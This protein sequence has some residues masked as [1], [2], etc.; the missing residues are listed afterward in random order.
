MGAAGP[1]DLGP[2]KHGEFV[3]RSLT[4]VPKR[5]VGPL[6]KMLVVAG[7]TD[8]TPFVVSLLES[9]IDPR[10]RR[11]AIRALGDFGD[12][13]SA[14]ALLRVVETGSKTERRFA[15]T[16]LARTKDPENLNALADPS[17]TLAPGARI[18]LLE[19]AEKFDSVG[20]KLVGFAIEGLGES[21]SA[22]RLASLKLLGKARK[23]AAVQPLVT[24][25]RTSK[26]DGE[27]SAVLNALLAIGTPRSGEA[28]LGLVH[29]LSDASARISYEARFRRL[30]DLFH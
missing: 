22:T 28:G 10:T 13:P 19:V 25:F 16:M 6:L 4:T 20:D 15:Q 5:D 21:D 11:H 30:R 18:V 23:N 7:A 17:R 8:C 9:E 27:R 29:L 24:H 1:R 3:A 2:G 26:E 14:E 12:L